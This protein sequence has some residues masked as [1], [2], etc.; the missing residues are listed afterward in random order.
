[1]AITQG[2]PTQYKLDVLQ[3]VHVAA[4]V[5]KIA[6]YTSAAVLDATTATYTATG[7]VVGTGYT[8]GGQTLVGYNALTSGTKGILDWT[9]NPSWPAASIT[10]RGAMIY[11][12]TKANKVVLI[13]DFGTDKTST[14]DTFTVTLPTPDAITGLIRLA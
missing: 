7:E 11:N 13:M 9:T 4:D 12:S 6:L 1:M 3:G 8:A 10:A 14:D 5:Y 2:F